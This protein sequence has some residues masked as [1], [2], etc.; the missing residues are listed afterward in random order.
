MLD[1]LKLIHERDSQDALG[2]AQKEPD[3]LSYNFADSFTDWPTKQ[4]KNIVFAGMGGSALAGSIA[5]SWPGFT[6]PLK[7]FEI[8]TSSELCFRGNTIYRVKLL[9]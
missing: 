9:W 6:C 7:S 1:D 5:K 3:Q 4:F 2:V 8:I